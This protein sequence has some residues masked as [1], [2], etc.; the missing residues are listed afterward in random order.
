LGVR[1]LAF[2]GAPVVGSVCSLTVASELRRLADDCLLITRAR[3]L[4]DWV[5]EGRPVTT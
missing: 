5:G 2:Q 3:H 1:R 4:V